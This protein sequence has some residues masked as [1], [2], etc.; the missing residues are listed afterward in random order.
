ME[1]YRLTGATRYLEAAG[2]FL[3]AR[4]REPS[5]M[6][7]VQGAFGRAYYQD[8]MPVAE[9]SEAVGHAVRA[10]YLA[11]G[12]MDVA[13]EAD[14]PELAA[15][16]ERLWDSAYGRKSYV[17]GGLGARYEGESFGADF[18]LPNEAAYAETCA[19]IGGV[20]WNWRM[21]L[22]S[23]DARYADTLENALYNG[24]LAGISLDGARYFYMNPLTSRGGYERSEWFDCACCPPNIARLLMSLPGYIYSTSKDA[25]WVHLY[26]AGKVR[27]TLPN[28]DGIAL[29]INTRYPWDGVIEI[30]VTEAP[31]HGVEL[32]LRIPAWSPGATATV[33]GDDTAQ[34]PRPGTYLG[35]ERTW[36]PGDSVTLTLPM[37]VRRIVSHP[38]VV[39]NHGRVALARGPLIYCIEETDHAGAD[40]FEIALPRDAKIEV[41]HDDRLLEGAAT[42]RA[43]AERITG[44]G[45]GNVLYGP[46]G[47][48]GNGVATKVAMT[49]V[50]FYA[51]GNRGEGAMQVWIPEARTA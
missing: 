21:L 3:E 50:P 9:Q 7:E 42:L 16:A 22:N 51:W 36:E 14:R 29:E 45:N 10:T 30:T 19:A 24:A 41:A 34:T 44:P 37:E 26:A 40:L 33:N 17:T 38:R 20:F 25:F 32:K 27:T 1:L 11:T 46:A 48:D 31:S 8:H 5:V 2:Y 39:E 35:I 23:Q 49:A 18:E 15:A 6:P 4:G 12:M 43:T 13:L 47:G 28:G